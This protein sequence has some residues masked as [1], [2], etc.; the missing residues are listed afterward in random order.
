MAAR[1]RSV[2]P[3]GRP[4][5][6][7]RLHG[8]RPPA[9]PKGLLGGVDDAGPVVGPEALDRIRPEAVARL[10]RPYLGNEGV[11]EIDALINVDGLT[12]LQAADRY[13]A[14]HGSGPLARPAPRRRGGTPRARRLPPPAP[15]PRRRARFRPARR[16]PARLVADPGRLTDAGA[17]PRT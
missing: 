13:L 7:N 10:D 16:G 9:E 4:Q 3:L 8:L 12:P 5:Y 11:E 15:P 1:E 17:A 2:I 14:G 6:L